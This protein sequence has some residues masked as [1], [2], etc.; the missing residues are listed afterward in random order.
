MDAEITRSNARIAQL[1]AQSEVCQR[2]TAVAGV[3]PLTATAF[4]AVVHDPGAC[5]N[6]R[7][8]AAWLS[9]VPTQHMS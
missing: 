6:G 2:L 9:V 7:H 5:K 1:A 4:V 3:G 8:C